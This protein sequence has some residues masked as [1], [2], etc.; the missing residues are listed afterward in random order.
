[1]GA[2]IAPRGEREWQ[3]TVPPSAEREVTIDLACSWLVGA[4]AAAAGSQI[5]VTLLWPVTVASNELRIRVW[6]QTSSGLRPRVVGGP[7]EELPAAPVA[8]RDSLPALVVHTAGGPSLLTLELTEAAGLA[9]AGVIAERALIQVAVGEAGQHRYLARFLL[10]KVS[11][12]SVDVELP[13]SVT[14]LGNLEV[15]LG[16]KRLDQVPALEAGRVLPVPLA[17]AEPLLALPAP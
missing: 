9:P 16:E 14:S 3:L 1:E 13:A 10:H 12:A 2:A 7:W 4:G 17:T 6:L 11:A 15:F 8:E 5:D